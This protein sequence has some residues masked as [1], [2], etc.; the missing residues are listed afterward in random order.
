MILT[1]WF[2]F[3]FFF[4][5]CKNFV[6]E[7]HFLKKLL[8]S[9]FDEIFLVEWKRPCNAIEQ[10]H[11]QKNSWNQLF[12]KKVDL[13]EKMLIFFRKNRDRVLYYFS[14]LWEYRNKCS[15]SN[16]AFLW[17]WISDHWFHVNYFVQTEKNSIFIL[18][19]CYWCIHCWQSS[20]FF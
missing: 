13:T 5:F 20:F 16:V 9:W 11:A 7:T 1:F 3:F 4:F 14:T 17:D 19:C 2:F 6:K 15:E 8:N 18:W 10:N 12:R